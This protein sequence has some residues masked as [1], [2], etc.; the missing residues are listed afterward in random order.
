MTAMRIA[1]ISPYSHGPIRGNIT[2]VNRIA[3]Y[4]AQAGATTVVLSADNLSEGLMKQRLADFCPDVIHG[5]HARLCGAITHNL[6][7]HFHLPYVITITGS[8][9]Y[10]PLL[11]G[12]PETHKAIQAAQAV[13]CFDTSDAD[14]FSKLFSYRDGMVA[15]VPQG[16]VPLPFIE[17]ENFRLNQDDFV[18]LLPAALR[19][20]KQVEFPLRSLA[21]LVQQIPSLR[22]VIA[23]G[24]IDQNYAS[25]IRAMLCDAPFASWFGE[26]AHEQMGSL[27]HRADLVLNCSRSES[28]PNSLLEAMALGKPV[29]A[30]DV[31]G[32]R[33]LVKH[34][35]TGWLY[36]GEADF[37]D[38]VMQLAGDATLRT[39]CGIRAREYVLANHSP[40]LEAGRHLA[41]YREL[42]A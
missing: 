30:A 5:F 28:M 21:K 36:N 35:L 1:L 10:D 20:V 18:L 39:E 16:V 37:R 3:R 33:S 38:R 25:F 12:H 19:A 22:L 40:E 29:L 6:A 42:R 13:V 15:V 9:I 17:G 32:N 4:L 26:V 34:T 11:L 14:M 24:I 31:P 8:D 23:G 7:G 2:S 41:L 27:Y